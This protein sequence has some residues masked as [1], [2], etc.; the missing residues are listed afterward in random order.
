MESEPLKKTL[1][2][3]LVAILLGLSLML[4]PL[5]TMTEATANSHYLLMPEHLSR[6]LE[7]LEGKYSANADVE[8]FAISFVIALVAYLLVKSIIPHRDYERYW[9]YWY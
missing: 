2:Y 7:K 8:V 5:I 3:C 1:L 6:Q 9:P 4:I